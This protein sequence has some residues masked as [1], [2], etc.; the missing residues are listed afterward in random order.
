[1]ASSSSSQVNGAFGESRLGSQP[2][3]TPTSTSQLD[4]RP[5]HGSRLASHH[6]ATL[7]FLRVLLSGECGPPS[8]PWGLLGLVPRGVA[9]TPS[10]V[11]TP[12]ILQHMYSAHWCSADPPSVAQCCPSLAPPH[13]RIIKLLVP[14]AP[15]VPPVSLGPLPDHCVSP[16]SFPV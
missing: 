14:V 3:R 12:S 11:H 15:C 8:L 6:P 9:L 1:M 16:A 4:I 10:Y 13:S 2:V 7:G 5:L